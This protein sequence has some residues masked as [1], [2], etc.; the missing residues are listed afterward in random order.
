MHKTTVALALSTV[1][2]LSVFS[3]PGGAH[4]SVPTQHQHISSSSHHGYGFDVAAAKAYEKS[5]AHRG[6]RT[7]GRPKV[8][9]AMQQ[10]PASYSLKQYA[11]QPG[12]Q[13]QVGSCVAWATGYT[14]YGVLMNEQGISG[15]PMAPM[16]I[17]SQ[18]AQGHDNGTWASVALPMEQAQGIDTQSDYWQGN[19]DYTTQPTWNERQNASGYRLSGYTDLT[20]SSNRREAVEESIASGLPVAIGFTVRS[21]FEDLDAGN[22]N[23]D[24]SPGESNLGGHEVTIVGYNQNGVEIENS[25]GSNWGNQGYFTAPW[26]WLEGSDVNEINSVGKLVPTS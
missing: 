5:V 19:Y 25:W 26:S 22:Y 11:L 17:Y 8:L 14:A 6:V 9:R 13:G 12:D 10:A 1:T 21:S 3:A 20:N 24:P 7:V 18:I 4:A 16:C 15:S 23:Y 2:A